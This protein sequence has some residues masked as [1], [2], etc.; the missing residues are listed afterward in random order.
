VLRVFL[1]LFHRPALQLGVLEDARGICRNPRFASFLVASNRKPLDTHLHDSLL[2][3]W[4]V[5]RLA[6]WVVAATVGSWVLVESARALTV[7]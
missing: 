3:S 2:R 7:F 1:H 6:A 4:K 5:L